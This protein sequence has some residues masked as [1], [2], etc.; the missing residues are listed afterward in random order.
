MNRFCPRVYAKHTRLKKTMYKS[1][2]QLAIDVQNQEK[3]NLLDL[4]ILQDKVMA[5]IIENIKAEPEEGAKADKKRFI[6][7]QIRRWADHS[8]LK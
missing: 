3:T 4:M 5:M 1:M 6:N 2:E 8:V 7:R